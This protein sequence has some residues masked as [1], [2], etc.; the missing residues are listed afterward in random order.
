M[1]F[2]IID[3]AIVEAGPDFTLPNSTKLS[4]YFSIV[5]ISVKTL[6]L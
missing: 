4:P 3:P 2:T 6:H 1:L 5:L